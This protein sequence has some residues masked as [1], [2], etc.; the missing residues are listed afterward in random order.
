MSHNTMKW[1]ALVNTAMAFLLHK[2]KKF[3]GYLSEYKLL[4]MDT[5]VNDNRK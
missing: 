3:L 4:N 2:S 5:H 1:M